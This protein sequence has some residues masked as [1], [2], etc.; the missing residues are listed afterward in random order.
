MKKLVRI[1]RNVLFVAVLACVISMLIPGSSLE[2]KTRKA[3]TKSPSE[4]NVFV[5]VNG[6]FKTD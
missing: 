2:A 5:I 3:P 6:T 4:G 1:S